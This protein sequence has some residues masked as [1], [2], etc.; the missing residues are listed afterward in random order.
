MR[1]T[2]RRPLGKLALALGPLALGL[3][4]T[5]LGCGSE[6]RKFPLDKPMATDLD[7][8]P[9]LPEPEEYYSSFLWDGADQMMFRPIAKFWKVDPGGEAVNVN[10]LDE[11][12]NSSWFTN[13]LGRFPLTLEQV[14][15]GPCRDSAP[16]DVNGPW[17]VTGA[18]PNG[19]NPGFPIKAADGRRYLLKFDGVVQGPRATAADVIVSK[20]Y[21]AAGFETPCNEIVFFDR[22]ILTIDPDAESEDATGKKV[23][24]TEAD[25]DKVFAKAI[26]L[27]DGRYRGSASLFLSGKPIGPFRYEE[28]RSDDPNDVVPHED[29]RELRGSKLLAA[30]TNHFDAREQNT[31]DMW[32]A[33]DKGKAGYIQHYIIDF[34][35]CF[36]SVWEPPMMGR[37]IGHSHYLAADHVFID[38]ITLGIVQRPW[39]ENRF[40]KTGSVLGY[41]QVDNFEPESY[42]P[43][44]PNPAMLRMTERDGAW[45]ARIMARMSPAHVKAMIDAGQ[46]RDETLEAELTRVV[47]GRRHKVL[48]RYLGV[49]S[50]LVEPEVK[51]SGNNAELCLEDLGVTAG[52]FPAAARTYG[53]RAWLGDSLQKHAIGSVRTAP[54][55]CAELPQ[56]SG[57]TPQKPQYIIMDMYAF[58][59]SQSRAPARVHLYHLG[60]TDFRIAGLERPYDNGPPEGY[61]TP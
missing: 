5:T 38:W 1:A 35:D 57:S 16:L 31:L 27:P 14:R 61:D 47:L 44:Y 2:T 55:L 43:G 29:R 15:R 54:K 4:A 19:A 12:P 6:L 39:D 50:S 7:K 21:F 18:K 58:T 10:A 20:F 59:G 11:V 40:A 22:K 3:A 28:T 49:V 32:V 33:P 46:L 36:G 17:T 23:K 13:R 26:K 37:R 56:L 30:W 48:S 52:L 45:M 41:Y 8:R 42:R 53:A 9:Y 25:L 60:G 24:M 34:G 51:V